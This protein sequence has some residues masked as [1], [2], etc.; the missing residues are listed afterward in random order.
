MPLSERSR[1]RRRRRRRRLESRLYIPQ[2]LPAVAGL[3]PSHTSQPMSCDPLTLPA[4]SRREHTRPTR[5]SLVPSR[6]T[7][8]VRDVGTAGRLSFQCGASPHT[9]FAIYFF[10]IRPDTH[11][12]FTGQISKRRT[13]RSENEI[14]F[15]SH[16]NQRRLWSTWSDLGWTFR[17]S[18][19][20]RC[21]GQGMGVLERAR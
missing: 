12:R 7:D 8:R 11:R 10:F 15:Q 17:M 5:R 6:P 2:P 14:I 9:D 1:R 21:L 19:S 4:R 20:T 13:T 16:A 3:S 18:R